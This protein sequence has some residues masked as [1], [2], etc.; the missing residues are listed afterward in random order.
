MKKTVVIHSEF[1][2]R[3][4]DELGEKLMGSFL[5]KLWAQETKPDRII[6]YNTGV[7][8]LAEG[9]PV[10]D[11]LD[12]LYKAGVD[13]IVCGTCAAFL[14][15]RDSLVLGRITDMQEIVASLMNSEEVITV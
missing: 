8:L 12:G 7:R 9:S 5:R 1:L 13:L 11:A 10:L 2:G 3:G 6:F 14:D 15:L 4:N